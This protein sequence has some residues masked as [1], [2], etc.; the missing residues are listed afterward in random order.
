MEERGIWA[1]E[2]V[3]RGVARGGVVVRIRGTG[4]EGLYEGRSRS[5]DCNPFRRSSCYQ[6]EKRT[7]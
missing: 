5:D 1:S 6:V 7:T 3:E 4:E 2:N